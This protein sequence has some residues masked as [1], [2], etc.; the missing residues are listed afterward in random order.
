MLS[1]AFSADDRTLFTSGGAG[2]LQAWDVP[3]ASRQLVLGEDTSAVESKYRVSLLAPD[4]HTVARVRS[5]T[6]WFEDTRTGRRLA[7]PVPTRD[8][9]FLWSPDSRWLL[10]S[11]PD[12]VL[13]VWDASTGSPA[14]RSAPFRAHRR[15]TRSPSV[16]A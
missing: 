15:T 12:P 16:R 10:S 3:G 7:E 1:V 2:L 8:E 13:T 4:G 9:S 5:G 11:R 6:L 14:A